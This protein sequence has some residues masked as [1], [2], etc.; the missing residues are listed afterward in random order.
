MDVDEVGLAQG[1]QEKQLRRL[2]QL[3]REEEELVSHPCLEV[4]DRCDRVCYCLQVSLLNAFEYF[5]SSA[6]VVLF[7]G[8]KKK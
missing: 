5:N 3:A 1:E 4:P 6:P 7:L 8:R 2:G